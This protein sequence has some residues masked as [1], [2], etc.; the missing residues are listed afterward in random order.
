MS[1]CAFCAQT[2]L[3]GD[4]VWR[5]EV[6]EVNRENGSYLLQKCTLVSCR[7]MWSTRSLCYSIL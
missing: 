5:W 2:S 1:A 6:R 4:L 7:A 3:Y